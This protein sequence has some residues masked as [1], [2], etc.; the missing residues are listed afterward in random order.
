MGFSSDILKNIKNLP[1]G[2]SELIYKFDDTYRKIFSEVLQEIL[3]G[4]DK[5][6]R[7]NRY[8][9]VEQFIFDFDEKYDNEIDTYLHSA[10]MELMELGKEE[11]DIYGSSE[12]FRL[13]YNCICKST[14]IDKNTK[15]RMMIIFKDPIRYLLITNQ[16]WKR[17]F[18]YDDGRI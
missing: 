12:C 16:S 6:C 8:L 5:I 1:D 13:V 11:Y 14:R 18:V 3:P 7:A 17:F 4:K 9:F 2:L 10:Y 15:E